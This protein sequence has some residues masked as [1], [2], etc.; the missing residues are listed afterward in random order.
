M[1]GAL[2]RNTEFGHKHKITGT[3]TLLFADGSRVPGAIS[4]SELERRLASTGG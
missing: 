2:V 3:P 1:P 4:A